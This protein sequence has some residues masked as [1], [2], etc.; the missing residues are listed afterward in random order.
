MSGNRLL[1]ISFYFPSDTDLN[2]YLRPV[3]QG[4]TKDNTLPSGENAILKGPGINSDFN[5]IL[6]AHDQRQ[7]KKQ[8]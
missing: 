3:L 6:P 4:R 7:A 1:F 5:R 8:K 2:R